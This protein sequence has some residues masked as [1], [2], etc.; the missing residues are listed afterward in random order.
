MTS[1]IVTGSA[2]P[3]WSLRRRLVLAVVG[4]L[5]ILAIVI[6]SISVLALQGFLMNRL[7]GQ[8]NA[9]N[10][11]SQTGFGPPGS[12][13]DG[14]QSDTFTR[15]QLVRTFDRQAPDT[16]IGLVS[17]ASVAGVRKDQAG[18]PQNL[19]AAQ[20]KPLATVPSSGVATTIDL[21]NG[22]GA[23]RA[24]ALQYA[25]GVRVVTALPLGELQTTLLQLGLIIAIVTA[26]GLLLAAFVA[27]WIVR[28][29]LRPLERV[30]STATRVAELPLDRGEVALGV[31]VPDDDSDPRTEV[32]Q[33]GAA[34]NRMLGH[35]A[36]ALTARQASENKVRQFVADASHELRT[37]LA[38]IR[39]YAELTRRGDHE[40]P[41]DVVHA[42][43]RVESEAKRMTSLVEDLLLLARLDEGRDL[44]SIPLDLTRLLIDAVSDAHA[45]S[46]EHEF[47]LDLPEE[48]VV[49]EGDDAR[50][51]QVFANLLA[52]ARVHTPA[53][54]RV[55]TA[56]AIEGTIA[57]IT[58]TDDGPGIP[59]ALQPVLFERFA[60][61]D[62]SRS[63]I[64]G[65]T[66]LGLAIVAAV[67]EGHG[68]TVGVQSEPG[69]TT[70]RVIL[71]LTSG[72]GG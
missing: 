24:V 45:A 60:R 38:A 36:S 50:L 4:L 32:G 30:V 59:E 61:G 3:R 23:Y 14:A 28:V 65:S 48:P 12:E 10:G 33:V 58:V 7:D 8:L 2:R 37:P 26:A 69:D 70:V 9:A 27:L 44:E 13:L 62:T 49:I 15:E 52:N 5:A 71:P 25:N 47:S 55:V 18:T 34:I 57:V 40:L 41:E 63:R 51:R 31:R 53:G 11:R 39:G 43:G 21:G 64:A 68:G 22:L 6:G 29:A 56:I 16:V 42:L 67:V 66:G 54:T 17:G 19:S 1:L 35:V 72:L 20:S 46:P